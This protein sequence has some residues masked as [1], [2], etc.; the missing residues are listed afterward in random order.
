MWWDDPIT[1]SCYKLFQENKNHSDIE[2]EQ[3]FKLQVQTDF[4]QK[5]Q[6]LIN[7]DGWDKFWNA[8]HFIIFLKKFASEKNLIEFNKQEIIFGTSFK[9]EERIKQQNSERL[10]QDLFESKE[11]SVDCNQEDNSK[12]AFKDMESNND[13]NEMESSDNSSKEE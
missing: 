6:E 3:A 4:S 5:M 1:K 12:E 10:I 11:R 8:G 13:K 2:V 9:V 7:L